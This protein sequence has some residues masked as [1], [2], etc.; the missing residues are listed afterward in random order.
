MHT[1]HELA[2]STLRW[3]AVLRV[4]FVR[5]SLLSW[6]TKR[7]F[8]VI[9]MHDLPGEQHS[10]LHDLLRG[11]GLLPDRRAGAPR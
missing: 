1:R 10:D 5:G 11:R 7:Q 6:V 3:A 8:I 2:E 9:P 4:A